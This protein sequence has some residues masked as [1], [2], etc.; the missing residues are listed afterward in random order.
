[1][2][3]ECSKS[4]VYFNQLECFSSEQRKCCSCIGPIMLGVDIDDPPPPVICTLQP[5]AVAKLSN[6]AV[7]TDPIYL[8]FDS[9]HW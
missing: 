9:G 2:L 3:I 4:H 8:G 7:S 5:V 6:L 1:M